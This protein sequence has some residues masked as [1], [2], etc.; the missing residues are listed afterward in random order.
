MRFA[1]V[2]YEQYV[3]ALN[4]ILPKNYDLFN[5]YM[6]IKLPKR[7]TRK[8]AGYDFFA[9]WEFTLQPGETIKVPSG[10]RV[11]LDDDRFLMCAP[12]SGLGFKYRVQLDNTL[13]IID[14]DYVESENE[15]H[16]FFKITNDTHDDKTVTVNQGDGFVQGIIIKYDVTE[17]DDACD[18]RNGGFGSTDR[19]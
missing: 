13:G 8:S 11:F 12:R 14:A 19:R 17:D 10:I 3:S 15:G 5:E 9:P 7:A 16:I 18:V 1:K 6:N 2:S 4:R